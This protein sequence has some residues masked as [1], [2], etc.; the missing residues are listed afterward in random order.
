M[1]GC[2]A[3]SVGSQLKSNFRSAAER[4]VDSINPPRPHP[5]LLTAAERGGYLEKETGQA[6]GHV[7]GA[8]RTWEHVEFRG[9]CFS[10][11][12]L[13]AWLEMGLM[14]GLGAVF[15]SSGLAL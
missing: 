2:L 11:W 6:A 4:G 8:G 1:A 12:L 10:A 13:M 9:S 3:D 15:C 7:L 5:R 14:K